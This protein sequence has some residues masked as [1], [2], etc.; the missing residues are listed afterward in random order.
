MVTDCQA[1][2][3]GGGTVRFSAT[4]T[5]SKGHIHVGPAE[6][7][8]VEVENQIHGAL[9][10]RGVSATATCPQ[11]VPIVPGKTFVCG[12]TVNRGPC[13]GGPIGEPQLYPAVENCGPAGTS[14]KWPRRSARAARRQRFGPVRAEVMVVGLWRIRC[15]C[16]TPRPSRPAVPK[17]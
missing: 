6:M 2:L 14:A 4:Q 9:K 12:A 17:R 15:S 8:A 11:H 13:I 1:T 7:I 16:T 5:D 3:A 10:K